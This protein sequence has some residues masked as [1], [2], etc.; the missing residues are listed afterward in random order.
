MVL[1]A[2]KNFSITNKLRMLVMI[3]SSIA[4]LMAC[5]IL[6]VLEVMNFRHTQ[7]NELSILSTIIADR[8]TASLTFDD[9][10]V[11]HETL[12]ALRARHSILSAYIFNDSKEI[13]AGYNRSGR[14]SVTL[15]EYP[16]F[17]GPRFTNTTL[18]VA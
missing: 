14:A 10:N 5:G 4:L 3:S 9:P 18:Q 2:F 8:T 16:A 17:F 1:T 11:A 13:F 12:N 6:G 15:P 7:A